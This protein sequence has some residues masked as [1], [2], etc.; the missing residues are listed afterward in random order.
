MKIK[1]RNDLFDVEKRV[2]EIDKNYEIYFDTDLQ[3]FVLYAFNVRQTVFPFDELDCRAIDY[4]Y[5]T[6]V[7]RAENLLDE[8][9]KENT[10]RERASI[11]K[12]KDEV[13]N[14]TSR[15]LRLSRI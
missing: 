12:A 8:I 7:S 6:R 15:R 10:E 11:K 1:I 5:K 13:E 4:V 2:K 3:K 14:E 9:D